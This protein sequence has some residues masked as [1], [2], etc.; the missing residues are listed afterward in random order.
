MNVRRDGNR[1][2]F[3]RLGEYEKIEERRDLFTRFVST[4]FRFIFV[5]FDILKVSYIIFLV[6]EKIKCLVINPQNYLSY[7]ILNA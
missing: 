7:V 1:F 5:C 3:K 4:I 2:A 6:R